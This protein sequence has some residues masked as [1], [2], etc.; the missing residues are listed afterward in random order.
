MFFENLH[1]C[2]KYEK[3][4]FSEIHFVLEAF[5]NGHFKNVLMFFSVVFSS[6]PAGAIF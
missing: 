2:K 3:D 5:T 1:F 4:E 6:Q